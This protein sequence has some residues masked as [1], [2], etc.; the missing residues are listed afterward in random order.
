MVSSTFSD[1][2]EHRRDVI[3]AIEA[4]GF[5]ANVM[6]AS[7][8]QAG[9]DVIDTSINMV[10]DSAA[11]IG[12]ISYSY[13]RTP[14]CIDR[15]PDAL[16]ISE[17]E[18]NEAMRLGRPIL[19]FIMGPKHL[20]LPTDVE[21]VPEKMV[22]LNA[23]RER[24]KHMREGSTV[25]RI[26]E[27]FNSREEFARA[28]TIAVGKLSQTLLPHKDRHN[29]TGEHITPVD[30]IET[31]LPPDLR[32]VPR[33]LGSHEFVGR[34]AELNT[35]DDW[36]A[37]ADQ[38]PT[39]LFVAIGGSGKSMVT[40]TWLTS[41]AMHARSDWAGRFWFSFYERGATMSRFCGEALAYM[42]GQPVKAFRKEK[43]RT[44]MSR[45]IAQLEARP[46]LI[47]LDGLE[48][49]LVAYHRIDAAQM[50]DEDVD[51][52]QDQI[53]DRDLRAAIDPEDEE[54]LRQLTAAAPSKL[55]ITSRLTPLALVNRSGMPLPGVR[56][57]MLPGLR[58]PDAE[59]LLRACG[60][61]GDSKAIQ[62][63]LQRNC[64]CHPLVIGALAGL[65]NN[66]MPD[67]GNF[68][69][70]LADP[71]AGGRLGLADLD[72]TQRRNH[73]LYVAIE[74]LTE[75]ARRLLQTLSL[76]QGGADYATLKEFN[77][78]RPPHPEEVEAPSPPETTSRWRSMDADERETAKIEFDEAK[79]ARAA[80][81]ETLKGWEQSPDARAAATRFD[82]TLTELERQGL[83]QYE[84]SLKRYDL[85]PVVRGV[86]AG[87]LAERETSEIGR[88]VV[89]HFSSR[90]HDPWEQAETLEDVAPGIQ[91]VATLTRMGRFEDAFNALDGELLMALSNN[92]MAF[93][94]IQRLLRPF[95]PHGWD[96]AIALRRDLDQC[97]VLLSV[98]NT[99]SDAV[100]PLRLAERAIRAAV[101][102]GSDE[103]TRN[104]LRKIS[105][106]LGVHSK[107]A[108]AARI[109]AL[110]LEFAEEAGN[111][112][113]IYLALFSAYWTEI[114][115][116]AFERADALWFR[117]NPKERGWGGF[118]TRGELERARAVDLFSRNELTEANLAEVERFCREERDREELVA[119]LGLRGEWHLSRGE[120]SLAIA[121]L[122]E[123]L[124]LCRESGVDLAT[125]DVML[126]LA[127][128]RAGHSVDARSVAERL[129]ETQSF[130]TALPI[131]EL[132]QDLGEPTLA[133]AA[134]LRAHKS[135]SG[136][137]EP[138][139]YRYSLDR[140]DA[141]LRKLGETPPEV[142]KHDPTNDE[143]FDWENDVRAVIEKRRKQRDGRKRREAEREKKNRKE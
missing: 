25:E 29:D 8:A 64:D 71:K 20:T 21:S 22:K 130:E 138:Y 4:L 141:L 12:V 41:R 47:V 111:A 131:A 116:G 70:W 88:Q 101:S 62:E 18:F 85:H 1:L 108:D 59:A 63:Y 136:S 129:H 121:P 104:C 122:T 82:E 81:V 68:D 92:L 54:L 11:F 105:A 142:P 9:T 123:A 14:E 57:E 76:L 6:E 27:L 37:A 75:P 17:L 128:L 106:D 137:G 53:A 44:L 125:L 5:R 7:G 110:T 42:T 74:A 19:L 124:H 55:L 16:S 83:L 45:L 86:A 90:P 139:V 48:R 132:W 126:A 84:H 60:V 87:G 51:A 73:I 102:F 23:F 80:Y 49:I 97:R 61:S 115:T 56:R 107:L 15:N 133:V 32:A 36:C 24:A 117:L 77:P 69:V 100:M 96:G 109:K 30:S 113:A 91:V 79:R 40:W 31:A 127:R 46:W 103:D 94:E 34:A 78:H 89:D 67:R 72:L 120:A 66:Y 2:K 65:V 35:L 93:G 52:A 38:H 143:V 50:R 33:Y 43:I 140:A 114:Y 112:H 98:S 99:F 39:L 119:C 28:A 26:Y 134:A 13:G 3:E 135:A 10:R 95:F 118:D 58:P